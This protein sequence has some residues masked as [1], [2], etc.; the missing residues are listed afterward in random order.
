M[1]IFHVFNFDLKK[2]P[3]IFD[4]WEKG[5]KKKSKRKKTVKD[6]K[7]I[8]NKSYVIYISLATTTK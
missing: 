1:H 6:I 3:P 2:T 8:V 4:K 5:K 7:P